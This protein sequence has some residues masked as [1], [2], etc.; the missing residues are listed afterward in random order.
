LDSSIGKEKQ[1]SEKEKLRELVSGV[2]RAGKEQYGKFRARRASEL[3]GMAMVFESMEEK[4]LQTMCRNF[5]EEL[6]A[7][8][9]K[10]FQ[11]DDRGEQRRS[12]PP[13]RFEVGTKI[14]REVDT[15]GYPSKLVDSV[16]DETD[17][18]DLVFKAVFE[19]GSSFPVATPIEEGTKGMTC[20][21]REEL[22]EDWIYFEV[23][24]LNRQGKSVMVKPVSG[25][26]D[27]L[28]AIY[29][30]EKRKEPSTWDV[31]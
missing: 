21:C 4:E 30:S 7:G 29:D 19:N 2:Y 15:S 14:L 12:F 24:R 27:D 17:S 26:E 31:D 16:F 1:M 20:F 9:K 25:S 10:R 22:P 23:V 28:Y 8:F 3:D 5:S 11:R 13:S 18:G 6:K